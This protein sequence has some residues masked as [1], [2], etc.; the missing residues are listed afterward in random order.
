MKIG[1]QKIEHNK[2][3]FLRTENIWKSNM[4]EAWVKDCW[5]FASKRYNPYHNQSGKV[6]EIK[7]HVLKIRLRIHIYTAFCSSYNWLHYSPCSHYSPSPNS[8]KSH[9]FFS[10]YSCL[11][12]G[13]TP[14]FR[15]SQPYSPWVLMLSD[16]V[17]IS[18]YVTGYWSKIYHTKIVL[19]HSQ[20]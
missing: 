17:I 9:I 18:C 16:T 7:Y 3:H 6:T 20:T 5:N 1:R 12:L 14:N 10:L 11:P 4:H 8:G 13:S 2:R 15:K 19:W